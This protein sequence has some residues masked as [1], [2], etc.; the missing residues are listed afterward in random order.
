M[1]W[2]LCQHECL[3]RYVK[4]GWGIAVGFRTALCCMLSTRC[5][6]HPLNYCDNWK[7]CPHKIRMHHWMVMALLLKISALLYMSERLGNLRDPKRTK[8]SQH[9]R[10]E[11][12]SA[13]V[14]LSQEAGE[15]RRRMSTFI[16][17]QGWEVFCFPPAFVGLHD[18][19]CILVMEALSIPCP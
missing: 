5:Q 12:S 6:R 15:G 10:S 2:L 18:L 1:N 9:F 11:G 16:F 19:L 7:N 4:A 13:G 3:A 14:S 17:L 8:T